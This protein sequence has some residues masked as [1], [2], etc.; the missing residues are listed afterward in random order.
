MGPVHFP[1]LGEP[2]KTH[3]IGPEHLDGLHLLFVL[4]WGPQKCP[5]RVPPFH[6]D[7]TCSAHTVKGQTSI[8]GTGGHP[9]LHTRSNHP[10]LLQPQSTLP[11]KRVPS[12][13]LPSVFFLHPGGTF[14][15]SLAGP[16]LPVS[17]QLSG[18]IT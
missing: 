1:S 5:S 9:L 12:H 13:S 4:K 14:S 18:L 6:R 17:G 7:Q 10:R 11:R 3:R 15:A 16:A 2:Q 8:Q